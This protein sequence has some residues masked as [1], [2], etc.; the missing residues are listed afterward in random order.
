MTTSSRVWLADNHL[1][2]KHG[3]ASVDSVEPFDLMYLPFNGDAP[4]RFPTDW[5]A[6]LAAYG[7]GLTVLRTDQCPYVDDAVNTVLATAEEL[8]V[9]ARAQT[10]SSGAQVQAESPTPYGV[11]GIVH[12]GRL[13]SYHY[14]LKK[15]LVKL[16]K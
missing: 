4:P 13:L 14:L 9:A 15:D 6:R 10:F 3:F 1:L 5:E 8:G 2:R 11:F 7:D 16:L 12:N